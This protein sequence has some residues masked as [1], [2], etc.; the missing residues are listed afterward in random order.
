MIYTETYNCFLL[1]FNFIGRYIKN[2]YFQ[3]AKANLNLA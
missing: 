3:Q 2:I 1:S